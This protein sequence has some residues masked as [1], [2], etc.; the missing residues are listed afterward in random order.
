MISNSYCER[1]GR[2]GHVANVPHLL[3]LYGNR[4]PAPERPPA[5]GSQWSLRNVVTGSYIGL[6]EW[7]FCFAYVHHD[8]AINLDQA[9]YIMISISYGRLKL[10]GQ[11]GQK[12]MWSY[13]KAYVPQNNTPNSPG[14]TAQTL[15]NG[16]TIAR[17]HEYIAEFTST[18]ITKSNLIPDYVKKKLWSTTLKHQRECKIVCWSK[19][20]KVWQ[21][22]R[23]EVVRWTATASIPSLQLR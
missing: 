4:V 21:D 18:G 23:P 17:K 19:L 5:P 7:D 3:D 12:G 8:F 22:V 16:V 10:R 9:Y 1:N 6:P 13:L 11:N 20:N 15:S 14:S 2:H